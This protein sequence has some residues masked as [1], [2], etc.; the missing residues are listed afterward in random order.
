MKTANNKKTPIRVIGLTGGIASGKTVAT[1]ALKN[2]GYT[3][4]D[5]DEVSRALFAAGT[6]GE[7]SIML[8]FPQAAENGKLNRA[9]LRKIIAKDDTA[10][11]RLNALTHPAIVEYIKNTIATATPPIVLS[12]PLLFESGLS[13]LC[14]TTVCVYCPL[15]LRIQ[16]L[17]ARD[18]ITVDDAQNIIA[19]QMPDD[20]RR[21]MADYT[22]SSDRDQG[23][24]EKEII[25]LINT[26][27]A[28]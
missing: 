24:F 27:T 18:G 3:V 13:S 15:T 12:V 4:I 9:A 28:N 5:A 6:D 21:A 10:R 1:A 16:R 19:A 26:L 14:D 8:A 22:V 7:K 25:E 20:K 2:A 11:Q 17:T 23:E